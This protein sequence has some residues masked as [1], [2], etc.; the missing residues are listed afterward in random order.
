VKSGATPSTHDIKASLRR[1]YD[2]KA[3]E[4]NEKGL[5]AF[6]EPMRLRFVEQLRTE[7]K[8]ELLEIGA[9]AGHEAAY[10]AEAGLSVMATDISP[11]NVARCRAKGVDS[12]VADFYELAYRDDTYDAVWAASCLVHVPDRDL[13]TVLG[14]IGRVLRTGGLL[15]VGLWGGDPAEGVWEDDPYDPPRFYAVRTDEAT[16]SRLAEW[17]TVERFDALD[18]EPDAHGLYYQAALLRWP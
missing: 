5:I 1:S 18:P 13:D 6:R 4:R 10:F 11:E 14:E 15:F 16:R 2:A 17:F 7:S 9:G 8:T 12:E 3:D